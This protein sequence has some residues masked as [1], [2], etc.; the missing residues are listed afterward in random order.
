MAIRYVRTDGHNGANGQNNTND[1][2]TGAWLTIQFGLDNIGQ[3]DNLIVNTGTYTLGTGLTASTGI[4]SNPVTFNGRTR[5]TTTGGT[6]TVT[7]ASAITLLTISGSGWSFEGITFDGASTATLGVNVTGNYDNS[8]Y[9]CTIKNVAG[10][11]FQTSGVTASLIQCEVTGCAGTNGSVALGASAINTVS[12]CQI[13]GNTQTGIYF[14]AGAADIYGCTV[15]NNSGATSDGIQLATY[16]FTVRHCT[17]HANGRDGVRM[18][19]Y[20]LMGEVAYN[21]LTSNTGDGI[22]DA[23]LGA[24]SVQDVRMHHNAFYNNGTDLSGVA[25]GPGDVTLTGLPYTNAGGGDF[26]LNNTAGAGAACRGVAVAMLYGGTTY[27]DLGAFQH[28][29]AGGGGALLTPRGFTGG[30]PA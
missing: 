27:P 4:V 19:T 7:T 26:T 12:N 3:N 30:Y 21:I 5:V 16:G 10:G 15:A 24:S 13:H 20:D 29:D 18:A 6:V 14:S 8:L 11:G 23:A 28:Q 2:T 9:R 17:V 1:P 22:N 25:S